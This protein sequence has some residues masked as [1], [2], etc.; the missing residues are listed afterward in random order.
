MM[1]AVSG[2]QGVGFV[3]GPGLGSILSLLH[4]NVGVLV[5]NQYTSPGYLSAIFC[6]I[7]F[8]IIAFYLPAITSQKKEDAKKVMNPGDEANPA[9]FI[10]LFLFFS[11][12]SVFA[13]FE[14]DFTILS[15]RDFDWG[16]LSNSIYFLIA[17]VISTV[18]YAIIGASPKLKA[19]DDRKAAACGLILLI[20]GMMCFIVYSR[21]LNWEDKLSLTQIAIGGA[22]YSIGYPIAS[23]YIFALYSK[24]LNPLIQGSKMGWITATGSLARMLGPIWASNALALGD[25]VVFGGTSIFLLVAVCVLFAGYKILVPHR[26]YG[27]ETPSVNA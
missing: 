2:A 5:V 14:T 3:V 15:K 6:L 22:V 24:I 16:S 23:T 11:T 9:I 4:F 20:F 19:L 21:P 7:C 10:S 8:F 18:M 1:A 12:V 13:I 27:K 17:A 25:T 26:D